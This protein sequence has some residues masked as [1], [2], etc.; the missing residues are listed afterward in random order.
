MIPL[1][2]LANSRRSIMAEKENSFAPI[3]E[4]EQ[5]P[6]KFEQFLD[7]NQ[8]KLVIVAIAIVVAVAGYIIAKG[9]TETKN[10]SAGA[11]F[12]NAQD[13]SALKEVIANHAGTPAAATAQLALAEE[14]WKANQQPEAIQT[15]KDF[16]NEHSDHPGYSKALLSL[17]SKLMDLG[18]LDEAK[19]FLTQLNGQPQNAFSNVT[20][21]LL[22]DLAYLEGQ[23]EEAASSYE[24]VT[25]EEGETYNPLVA[26]SQ[27]RAL[28]AST[29]QPK[30]SQPAP[31]PE[32]TEEPASE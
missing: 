20:E 24:K 10:A 9:V 26:I 6:S 8:K 2:E 4:I 12:S 21:I 15:L 23:K 30:V 32:P 27:N 18:K 31:T 22:G 5:G 28:A 7:Q 17:G 1:A 3:G 19:K 29:A 25:L 14:Q 16:T 13:A 11:V